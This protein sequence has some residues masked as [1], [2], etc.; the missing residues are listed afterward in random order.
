MRHVSRP[1][2]GVLKIELIGDEIHADGHLV[3]LLATQ[4]AP[5]SVLSEFCHAMEEVHTPV[6]LV[7]LA[8]DLVA[9]AKG[10]WVHVHN[11]RNV[12]K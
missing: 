7:A 8:D 3:G 1:R 9:A 10:G 2:E 12:L 11:I 5:A 4:G 6:D